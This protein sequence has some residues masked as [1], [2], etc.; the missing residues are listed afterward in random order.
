MTSRLAVSARK[1]PTML[2]ATWIVCLLAA[3]T[4]VAESRRPVLRAA[5]NAVTTGNYVVVLRRNT[6]NETLQRLLSKASKHSDDNR[7]HRYVETVAK[8]FTLKLSPY[9]LEVVSNPVLI[10]SSNNDNNDYNLPTAAS[11]A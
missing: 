1:V 11:L 9:S 4:C 2:A 10:N 6:T 3:A 5:P 7:V 8:A